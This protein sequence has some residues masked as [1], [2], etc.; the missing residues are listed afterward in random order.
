AVAEAKFP[1]HVEARRWVLTAT[2]ELRR[3][4]PDEALG[5]LDKAQSFTPKMPCLDRLSALAYNARGQPEKALACL[6]R[7]TD[8]LGDDSQTWRERGVALAHLGRL[9][10]ALG[11]FRESLRDDLGP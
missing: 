1:S 9:A 11:A 3:G 10:E 7:Y 2:V 5:S 8:A 4:R 6:R